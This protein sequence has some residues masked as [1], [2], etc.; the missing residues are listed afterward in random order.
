M[1]AYTIE[2]TPVQEKG[3]ELYLA[4]LEDDVAATKEEA[5]AHLVTTQ[6]EKKVKD[7]WRQQQK[8]KGI[9]D[10]ANELT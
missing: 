1:A 8:S 3:L 10:M 5:F 7:A 9:D 4:S 2:L 6:M